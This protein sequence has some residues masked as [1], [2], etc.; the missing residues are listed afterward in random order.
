MLTVQRLVEKVES[1]REGKRMSEKQ[2][3]GD[4]MTNTTMTIQ[5]AYS[6]T[7]SV[8]SRLRYGVPEDY[9][10]G[11]VIDFLDRLVAAEGWTWSREDD[12]SKINRL[13]ANRSRSAYPAR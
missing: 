4:G 12:P 13:R 6:R 1:V 3:G 8:D 9:T 11:C 10:L 7:K 2:N 5:V